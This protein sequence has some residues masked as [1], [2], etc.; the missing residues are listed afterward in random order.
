MLDPKF[1]YEGYFIS[2]MRQWYKMIALPAKQM[3]RMLAA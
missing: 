2:Y 3:G 1:Y